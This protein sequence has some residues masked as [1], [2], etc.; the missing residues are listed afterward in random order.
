EVDPFYVSAQQRIAAGQI[1]EEVGTAI[2][3]L[4]S[5]D[6]ETY[7]AARRKVLA[8]GPVCHAPVADRARKLPEDSLLRPRLL[9]IIR[10][11]EVQADAEH[12]IRGTEGAS[13]RAAELARKHDGKSRIA[14]LA[15]RTVTQGGL[16][17]QVPVDPRA[18]MCY[19]SFPKGKHGY[20]GAVS[21]MFGNA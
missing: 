18:S 10:Q 13:Q 2:D 21:L 15:A 19:Y 5:A 3:E 1:S 12:M 17:G 8:Q 9:E 14:A 4:L 16:A 6:V 20:E 7:L 11:F